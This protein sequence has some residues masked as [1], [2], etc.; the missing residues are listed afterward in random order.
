MKT[1]KNLWKKFI[2]YENLYLASVKSQKGKRWKSTTLQFNDNIESELIK[3]QEELS[4]GE[5]NPGAYRSFT[6]RE[7]KERVIFAAPYRDRIVHH[8]L[9]NI[10]EPIWEPRLYYLS[11]ACR[12]NK[13]SHKALDVCQSYLRK[14]KYVLKCDIQKYF[15]S[16]DHNVLKKII[17]NKIADPRLLHLLDLI[18]DSSPKEISKE[19]PIYYFDGDNL[20]TPI[21]RRKGIPIGNLTSQFFANIYLNELDSWVK[22]QQKIKY[23][24][25]YMDD[26]IIF[27]KS[28]EVL[29]KLRLTIKDYL[30]ILRLKLHE[31]KQQVFPIKNGV[32]FLGF[33][34]YYTHRR[35]LLS[36]IRLFKKRMKHKQ[37]LFKKNE[38]NRAEIKH[39]IMAWLGHSRHGNTYKLRTVMF[40]DMVF[41]RA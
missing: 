21:E 12:V 2:S 22:N 19:V 17:K 29:N 31:K 20:L 40:Q 6:I 7:P 16:I 9:M 35:L 15:P 4:S 23:Y 36:N 11:Y 38:I 10:L 39:S 27:H 14:N 13:G 1:Y 25:R 5:Y 3:L 34:I 28:K 26:F 32:P 24:I 37:M 18:I 30:V 33:H 8:A 41:T